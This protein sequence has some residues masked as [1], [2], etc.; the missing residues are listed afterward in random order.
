M[1][2]NP[3]ILLKV[4]LLS[5]VRGGKMIKKNMIIVSVVLS[6][7]CL[8]IQKANAQHDLAVDTLFYE[9]INYY[10][11]EN[12]EQALEIFQLLDKVYKN[13]ARLTSS[14]LM[15]G[16]SYYHLEKYKQSLDTFDRLIL[17]FPESAY[18]D[19]AVFNKMLVYYKTGE[20]KTAVTNGIKLLDHGG[21]ER[22]LKRAAE[23]ANTIMKTKMSISELKKLL[24]EMQGERGKAAVTLQIAQKEID[25]QHYQTV[26]L[27]INQFLELYPESRYRSRMESTLAK[28]VR[29]GK[30]KMKIGV[31]LPL[32]GENSEQGNQLLNGIRFAVREFN[33][34]SGDRIEIVSYDSESDIVK[35][36]NIAKELGENAEIIAVIGEY[37]DNITAAV[38]G[39]IRSFGVPLIAPTAIMNGI[40]SIGDEVFQ[41]RGSLNMQGKILADY[42]VDGLGLKT[43]A[44][45]GSGD[46]YGKQLR[47]AFAGKITELGGEILVEQWYYEGAEQLK[48]QFEEIRKAGIQKMIEDSLIVM[49]EKE[50][51]EEKYSEQ[52]F[53]HGTLYVKQ[54]LEALVDSTELKVTSIDA[55]FLPIKQEELVYVGSQFAFFNIDC[56]LF[57]SSHWYNEEFLHKYDTYIKGIYFVTDMFVDESDYSYIQ[58]LNNY[59]T[60]FGITPSKM[61]I[62]GFDCTN[63]ILDV[64][65]EDIMLREDIKNF[66]SAVENFQGIGLDVS[67]NDMRVNTRLPLLQFNGIDVIQ[68]K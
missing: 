43:F 54:S 31:I 37:E 55:L 30:D 13:H 44:I 12:Y 59:R 35:A 48:T 17:E 2:T 46:E 39:V 66:L 53:Q 15:Q 45:L 65:S 22:V 25:N 28:A 6:G 27:Y 10:N 62:A 19:D 4:L 57:G 42:A 67:F 34:E 11:N 21:D 29:L 24:E 1:L 38:A 32:S 16:K 56:R 52:Q 49:V 36:I 61:D 50:E 64:M 7:F 47:N 14:L 68:I 51:W 3:E 23:L 5:N 60:T 58:F 41:P 40:H 20:M 63:L 26:I 33:R 8:G 9:G 18:F